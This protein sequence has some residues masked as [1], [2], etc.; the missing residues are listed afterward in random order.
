MFDKLDQIFVTA[1]HWLVSF[2]P[3]AWRPLAS[4]LICIAFI[5]SVFPA[6]FS[7][8]TIFE[9]K[10]IGRI[11]NRYGPNR[12]GIPFTKI[13]LAGFGQFIPDGVKMLTK[14]DIVPRAA[15]KVVHFLAPVVMLI[16]VLLAYAV[17]PFGKN[18]TVTDYDAGL[19]FFFAVGGA[20]EL[21]VFM[22]GWSSRNKYS[23]LG[24]MRAIA[25][26]ISYEIP[27]IISA[28]TVIMIAGSLSLVDIVDRQGGFVFGFV[29]HWNV[30]TPWGLAGF[31]M[32]LIASLAESNR[33][34]FDIPE[35]ESELIAGHLTEYS[36]FKYALFFLAEYL[37]MFAV[38][39][40]GVTLF[41]GG[42]HAP[43]PHLDWVP[44]YIWFMGKLICIV[45]LFIW[46]RGTLPRL[47]VDQLLNFAWKFML[48][49]ALLNLVVAAVWHYTSVW[50]FGGAVFGR[51]L[52]CAAMVTIPY[53][54]L[55]R[56][57]AGNKK[58]TLRVYRFAD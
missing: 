37:G 44:T 25:Q 15:D 58:D 43:L 13:R 19:L 23:L 3:E 35:A 27:L 9:R 17:L 32:F 36:G 55:G 39:G 6:V 49:M 31:I 21:S 41:L 57:L 22:A 48:P 8:T 29:P 46:V 38:S 4:S 2:L 45:F 5:L 7:V 54:W 50:T 40:L 10:G 26:M 33:S 28:V 16:P 53:V 18:M 52:L 34:P 14:E 1:L 12:V 11:Q 42:W 30:L 24:A 20:V 47:R 51:W 56:S